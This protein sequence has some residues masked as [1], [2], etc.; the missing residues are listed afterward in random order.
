MGDKAYGSEAKAAWNGVPVRIT[1]FEE[2]KRRANTVT[3]D[4]GSLAGTDG[5]P[6]EER[7]FGPKEKEITIAGHVLRDEA[8]DATIDLDD[9]DGGTLQIWPFGLAGWS[10]VYRNLQYDSATLRCADP[11]A[12]NSWEGHFFC[13]DW[14][15]NV[16]PA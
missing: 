6:N 15:E 12:V 3:T 4:T 10:R 11:Q 7:T 8:P 16:P 14:D 13:N 1:R 9:P 5:I 2:I